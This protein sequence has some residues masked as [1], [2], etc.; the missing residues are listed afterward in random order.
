MDKSIKYV[1]AEDKRQELL[2]LLKS[3]GAGTRAIRQLVFER[4]SRSLMRWSYY[5]TL[6]ELDEYLVREDNVN[7][8][9]LDTSDF[10]I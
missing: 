10:G 5:L 9:Q 7:E 2:D 1:V 4:A 3:R 8:V 6:E